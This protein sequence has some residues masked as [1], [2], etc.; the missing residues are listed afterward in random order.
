[1]GKRRKVYFP[2]PKEERKGIPLKKLR[3][4]YQKK[5]TLWSFVYPQWRMVAMDGSSNW[6]AFSTTTLPGIRV[7]VLTEFF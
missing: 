5:A 7:T 6:T 1:M 4:G 2:K 3:R